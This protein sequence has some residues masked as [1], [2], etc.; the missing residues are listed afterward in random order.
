M[1]GAV[2]TAVVC[3]S[4]TELGT[5]LQLGVAV[6]E[7]RPRPHDSAGVGVDVPGGSGFG[8]F[9]DSGASVVEPPAVAAVGDAVVSSFSPRLVV[10]S[11]DYS[12]KDFSVDFRFFGSNTDGS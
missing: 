6:V 12:R 2:P 4:Q 8:E 7:P 5:G 11:A 3:P 1:V 9:D 10:G